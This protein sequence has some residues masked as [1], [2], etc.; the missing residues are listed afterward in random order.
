MSDS[1]ASGASH[2][3]RIVVG[4]DGSPI[5]KIALRWAIDQARLTGATV[6]AVLAWQYPEGMTGL[7]W[8]TVMVEEPDLGVLAEKELTEAISETAGPDPDVVVNPVVVQ[9]WPAEVLLDAAEGA[10]LL[11]VG[12]RGRSGF[13]SVLLGSV[14]QNCA[15]HATCP[16]LIIRTANDDQ[17]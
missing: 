8:G 5:S 9:G 6:D 14:S 12:S 11:V 3:G 1:S 16:L 7:S 15:H 10:D 4:V 17:H 13:T 2:H